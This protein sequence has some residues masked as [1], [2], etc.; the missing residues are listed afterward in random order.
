M[1]DLLIRD[2]DPH[3]RAALEKHARANRLSLSEA[4]KLW[5]RRG[6]SGATTAPQPYGLGSRLAGLG[7]VWEGL[8]P[9]R[10]DEGRALPFEP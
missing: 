8:I 4:A 5:L 2:L 9:A 6:F 3:L 7:G 1:P 10:E